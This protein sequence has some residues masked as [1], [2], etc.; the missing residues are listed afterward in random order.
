MH[1]SDL[2]MGDAYREEIDRLS[3]MEAA[4]AELV[5][6]VKELK[7]AIKARDHVI[8]ELKADLAEAQS[9][10]IAQ[11]ASPPTEPLKVEI[12]YV[13]PK[14]LYTSPYTWGHAR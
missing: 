10:A 4:N 14:S 13:K 1:I 5:E 11:A 3:G 7:L 12:D 9:V 2:W 6:R 8:G